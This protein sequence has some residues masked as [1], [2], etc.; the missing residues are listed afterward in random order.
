[1]FFFLLNLIFVSFNVCV[2]VVEFVVK[3]F[4]GG[5]GGIGNG[6][7]F[8]FSVNVFLYVMIIFDFKKM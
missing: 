3:R 1:M 2:I 4:L 5:Y 8:Y 6:V 7:K